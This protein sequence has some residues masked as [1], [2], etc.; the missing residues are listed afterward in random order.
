VGYLFEPSALHEIAKRGV[1]L[2]RAEMLE[3][4][5]RGLEERYPGHIH[6]NDDWIYATAGGAMGQMK[7]LHASPTEYVIF[8]GTPLNTEGHSGRTSCEIHQFMLDGEMWCYEEGDLDRRVFRPG[9][10]TMVGRGVARHYSVPDHAWML[11]YAR[12]A[13]P[14]MLPFAL[15]NQAFVT[16]DGKSVFRALSSFGKLS[17]R[18]LRKGKIL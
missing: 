2:P 1:G 6:R 4:V 3:A 14:L 10:A 7:F 16:L 13:L 11:E 17:L 12:G 9:D 5:T 18:S 15:A 8:F